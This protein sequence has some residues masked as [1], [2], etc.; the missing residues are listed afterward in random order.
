MENLPS[1]FYATQYVAWFYQILGHPGSSRLY[2]AMSQRFYN[3]R[4]RHTIDTFKC[5]HCQKHKIPGKGY[6]LLPD[7]GVVSQPWDEIAVDLIDPFE[8]KERNR[9][10]TFNALTM[11]DATTNLV[12]ITRV[13]NKTC[14][15]VTNK[16]RQCWLS[17]YPRS[18]CIVRSPINCKKPQPNAIGERM[19]QTV[20]NVLR[21]LLYS[22]QSSKKYDSS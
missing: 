5:D 18:Q 12:K 2:K 14:A 17:R 20:A 22:T 1:R 8:V 3:S 9:L 15:H 16:L 10:M 7:R 4:L 21:V 13:D 11:I 19:H 6:G